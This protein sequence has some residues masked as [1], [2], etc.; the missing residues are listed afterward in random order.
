MFSKLT[1]A[2]FIFSSAY[3]VIFNGFQ[4]NLSIKFVWGILAEA[5]LIT[6]G[7]MPMLTEKEMSKAKYLIC[8]I[9]Y[10]IY[11]DIVVLCFGFYFGWFSIRH[12]ITIVAME[13]T[14]V[15]TFAV[16]YL[17]MYFSVKRSADKMNERLKKLKEN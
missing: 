11:T 5:F 15:I 13:I 7:Y 16:V 2:I 17:I 1:T 14:F 4:K 8:N 6:L 3:I 9:L 12:P 10:F